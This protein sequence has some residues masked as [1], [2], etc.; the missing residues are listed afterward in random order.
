MQNSVLPLA[1]CR[2]DRV[3]EIISSPDRQLSLMQPNAINVL[4]GKLQESHNDLSVLVYQDQLW[5]GYARILATLPASTNDH[6][7]SASKIGNT[8]I[9]HLLCQVNTAF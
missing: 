3:A 8:F 6:T 4:A 9:Y 7:D 2:E 5:G 1:T